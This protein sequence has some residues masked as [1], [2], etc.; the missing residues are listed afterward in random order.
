MLEVV[1]LVPYSHMYL[2]FLN[3]FVVCFTIL[4]YFIREY[5]LGIKEE[6]VKKKDNDSIFSSAYE[7]MLVEKGA[8]RNVVVKKYFSM[9]PFFSL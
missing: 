2:V 9:S 4:W 5:H 8:L 1:L 3:R 6:S 7:I